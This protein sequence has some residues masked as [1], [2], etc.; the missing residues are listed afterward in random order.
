MS[1]DDPFE[2]AGEME[3]TN[4]ELKGPNVVS[5]FEVPPRDDA[6]KAQEAAIR[7][8]L[9]NQRRAKGSTDA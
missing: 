4:L 6:L 3:P 9:S 7:K 5:T 8:H 2:T 1:E